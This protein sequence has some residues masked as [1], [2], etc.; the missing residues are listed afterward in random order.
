MSLNRTAVLKPTEITIRVEENKLGIHYRVQDSESGKSM[1]STFLHF[2]PSASL[3]AQ[4]KA[5][6]DIAIKE[7]EDIKF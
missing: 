2:K 4:L 6:I 3:M 5:E 7:R 1:G